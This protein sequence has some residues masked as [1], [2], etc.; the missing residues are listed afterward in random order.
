MIS[1]KTEDRKKRSSF[2]V[3]WMNSSL[4]NRLIV[5][6]I[7]PAGLQLLLS[8]YLFFEFNRFEKLAEHETLT[9]E[10]IGR[11][12][13]V[14]TLL[15]STSLSW[16]EY[17]VSNDTKYAESMQNLRKSASEQLVALQEVVELYSRHNIGDVTN[18]TQSIRNYTAV[19]LPPTKVENDEAA[20]L[21]DEEKI[22]LMKER[23]LSPSL[24]TA[25][26]Q[27]HIARQKLLS[28]QRNSFKLNHIDA[29]PENRTVLKYI[30]IALMAT[31]IGTSGIFILAYSLYVQRRLNILKEN[32]IRIAQGEELPECTSGS[33]E[34]AAVDRA[35]H[36]M[37]SELK[38][39][40]KREQEIMQ[41]K[42]HLMDMV[43]HDL[44][45]PLTNL[46]AVLEI[47]LDDDENPASEFQTQMYRRGQNSIK[48]MMTLTNDL[49][50]LDKAD[51][52]MLQIQPEQT[53]LM[54]IIQSCIG[55]VEQIAGARK[56][57]I[58]RQ[59]TCGQLVADENR[60]EQ[61]LVNLLTNAIKF[62][63]SDSTVSIATDDLGDRYEIKVSD[64]G[65]GIPPEQVPYVFDRFRQ[66]TAADSAE[67]RG[68]GLGLAICK[69]IVEL[70]NGQISC[71]SEV[72][73]GTVFNIILPKEPANIVS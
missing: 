57:K 47:L 55:L 66:V 67:G 53:N 59:G 10:L 4:R 42:Q 24:Q 64:E 50:L 54:E 70:H 28:S 2:F 1:I 37:D 14:Q 32:T 71:H 69:A 61:V 40:A 36:R 25:A 6:S 62:S 46:S 19:I 27:F 11:T 31:G 68:A 43:A 15:L 45:T 48:R 58:E 7:I 63:P 65:R 12:N 17:L 38:E 34:L 51:A 9:K 22:A 30:V 52:G 60:L 39:A 33:D 49:L 35:M 16:V 23:L 41:L 56:V 21:S 5:Y 3:K 20:N 13:W 18:L 73:K 8:V 26:R 29:T 72:G 44:R